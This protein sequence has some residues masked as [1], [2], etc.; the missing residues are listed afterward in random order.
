[1]LK[2]DRVTKRTFLKLFVFASL[3]SFA[4]LSLAAAKS[5][6]ESTT[7]EVTVPTITLNNGDKIPQL[8]FGL[9]QLS[10]EEAKRSVKMA[11]EEGYRLFDTAQYYQNEGETYQAIKESGIDRK[12]VYITTKVWPNHMRNGTV[13]ESLDKSLELLGGDYIDLVLIH[14]P[15]DGYNKQTWQ[16]MEE[17]VDKGKIKSIGVSNFSPEQLKELIGYARIKPVLNQI[18][19]HPYRNQLRNA[20]LNEQLGV[21]VETWSPLG[22]GRILKDETLT[23]LANKYD[24]SVAQ[25][26][27]R[28][29]IQRDLITI[30]R[31]RN[32]D[33]IAENINV[34]NFQLSDEDMAVINNLDRR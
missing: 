12:E 22:S 9:W 30:P 28:W 16:I 27:L 8:G 10:K 32:R 21:V 17:Y 18:E 34:F 11:L 7:K 29:N 15:A 33:H 31:S 20:E 14:W 25:I 5:T 6:D 1:M 3:V 19:I 24:K 23:K 13:R 2:H 4:N 26:I